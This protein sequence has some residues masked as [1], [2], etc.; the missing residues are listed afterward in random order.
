MSGG[1][2]KAKKEPGNFIAEWFGHRVYPVVAETASSL[3]DQSAQRCPFLTEVTGKQTK[4]VK[5]ANSAGVC[6]ISSNSNGPRQDWLACPFRALDLPMLHDAAH[7]LFGYAKGDDVSIVAVPKLEEKPVAADVRKRV[8]AGEPTIVYFQNKLGGEISI[9]PTDRSPE[10]SFD[11]TMIELVPDSSGELSVGRYGVFEIQTMDFHGTYQAAVANLRNARHMHAGEFGE[12]IASHPQWLSERV[13]GPNIANAFKRTFY[14]MMFKF[15][16]G[17]HEASAGCILAIPRAVWE[18]WQRHLGRPDLVD[19]GD[20]T[21]RLVRPG[22]TPL[23]NPP[24]WIYVFDTEV[25]DTCTPNALNLWRV[26][27]TDAA[28]LGHYTLDVAPE[29]ALAA[30]GSVDRLHSVIT[31]RLSKYLPELK[32]TH[33]RIKKAAAGAGQLTL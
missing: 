7:R 19:H 5:R 32:P 10:F 14:Q 17:A 28:T 20:G 8:A 6:T 29:A 1:G 4:C 13:E 30:G 3:A 9:S 12:T 26:I 23:E 24:A 18:S 21:V 11:A 27:G 33:G 22:D 25:S 2:A 16:V 31:Q 15:Q